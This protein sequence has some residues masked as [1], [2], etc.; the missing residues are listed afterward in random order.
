MN[1]DHW[2]DDTA[3][4]E[5]EKVYAERPN[6]TAIKRQMLAL[7]AIGRELI[8][9]KPQQLDEIPLDEPLRDAIALARRL[10]KGALKRQL[11]YIEKLMRPLD[12]DE[13]L[14]IRRA[15][16]QLYQPHR[17]EVERLHR[18]ESWRDRLLQ[19]DDSTYADILEQCPAADRQHLRQLVRNAQREAS[20]GKPPKSARALF[21][22][23]DEM[24]E[25]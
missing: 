17:D 21:K 14:A 11:I 20:Q 10:K 1:H 18:I 3:D 6:K 23:L 25:K 12:E 13:V 2:D 15:L 19:G 8:A 4:H 7:R 16:D 22:Y 9:L 24:L 5:E